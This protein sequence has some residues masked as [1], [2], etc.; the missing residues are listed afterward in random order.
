MRRPRMYRQGAPIEDLGDLGNG[1]RY[2]WWRGKAYHY[3]FLL[4]WQFWRIWREWK[5]G[6]LY[7]AEL[8]EEYKVWLN[9]REAK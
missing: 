5:A 9:E 8:T 2:L 4:N 6:R 7:A 3:G 1:P